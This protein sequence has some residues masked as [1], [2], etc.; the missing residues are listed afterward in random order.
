MNAYSIPATVST[1]SVSLE[2]FESAVYRADAHFQEHIAPKVIRVTVEAIA[3][4]VIAFIAASRFCYQAGVWTAAFY[5]EYNAASVPPMIEEPLMS[6]PAAAEPLMLPAETVF[7]PGRAAA[8][9]RA[10]RQ[11]HKATVCELPAGVDVIVTPAPKV[12]RVRKPVALKTKAPGVDRRKEPTQ[13]K[14]GSRT[15]CID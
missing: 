7:H 8:Q 1:I 13:A 14:V 3:F 10:F 2:R 6:L 15:V 5:A 11:L 12:K 9:D 4:F